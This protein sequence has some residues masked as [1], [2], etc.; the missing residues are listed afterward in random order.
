MVLGLLLVLFLA[1]VQL[2]LWAYVRTLAAAATAE[3]ARNAALAGASSLAMTDRVRSALGGG[4]AA[5]TAD[6]LV[7]TGIA[8]AQFI[9]VH[10]TLEAPGLVGLLDGVMPQID[11]YGHAALEDPS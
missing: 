10:C 4:L 7:C 8:D 3:A 5:G 1:L 6:T 11:V 9:G 2:C